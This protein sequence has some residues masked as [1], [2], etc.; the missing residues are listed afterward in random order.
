MTP[1]AKETHTKAGQVRGEH[2]KYVNGHVLRTRRCR[3]AHRA[4]RPLKPIDVV[5][6]GALHTWIRR[7]Y[8]LTAIC[9][10]CGK[11][12][13]TEYASITD[14]AYVRP[15]TKQ[16]LDAAFRELCR[17]CHLNLDGSPRTRGAVVH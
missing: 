11:R 4:Q 7:R 14:H 17:A 8:P 12:G 16:E 1:V 5:S 9:A 10:D 13:R 15:L 6:A 2:I 3:D